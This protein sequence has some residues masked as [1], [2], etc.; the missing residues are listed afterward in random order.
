MISVD[1]S[2]MLEWTPENICAG[3]KCCKL[4]RLLAGDHLVIDIIPAYPIDLST[5]SCVSLQHL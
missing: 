5:N 4:G 2:V 1:A 3:A